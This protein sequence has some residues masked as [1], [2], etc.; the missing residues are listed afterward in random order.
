MNHVMGCH[1][2]RL[3]HSLSLSLSLPPSQFPSVA[4]YD[5]ELQRHLADE[6]KLIAS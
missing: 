3:P 5:Q 1:T 2:S 4:Y 6:I